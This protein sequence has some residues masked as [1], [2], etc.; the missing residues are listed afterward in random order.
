MKVAEILT[1]K[2]L[3]YGA[4]PEAALPALDWIA[5]HDGKFGLFINGKF[6][7]PLSQEYFD[8]NNPSTNKKL[9]RIAQANK[10]RK[11]VV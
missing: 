4:A 7:E 9:A 10:D 8:S 6:R 2:S 1:Q 5:E 11:S 3:P